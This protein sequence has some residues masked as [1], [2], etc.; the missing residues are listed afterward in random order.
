MSGFTLPNT[1]FKAV[2]EWR[3]RRLTREYPYAYVDGTYLK[4]GWGGS[5]DNV[6][7][8]VAIGVNEDGYR[9]V[10]GC[11][12][13]FTESSECWRDFLSWLRSRGLR[14][15]RMFTGDKVAGMVNSIAEAVLP[16]RNNQRYSHEQ[17]FT[18]A[19]KSSAPP[20]TDIELANFES[21]VIIY[22][23]RK[24]LKLVSNSNIPVTIKTDI[25]KHIIVFKNL[26]KR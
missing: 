18:F 24:V 13:G 2:E 25:I 26:D 6:A 15:V 23:F 7:V 12:E 1:A 3:R 22:L 17:I 20:L 5:Y 10:I 8:M 19:R 14:G 21:G 11:A 9:E 16:N 4:H